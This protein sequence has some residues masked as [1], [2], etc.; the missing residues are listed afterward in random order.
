MN[1]THFLIAMAGFAVGI[2]FF[3]A[4]SWPIR[5][6]NYMVFGV[7]I[8]SKASFPDAHMARVYS[9]PGLGEQHFT[10]EVDGRSVYISPDLSP[11][12]LDEQIIWSDDGTVVSLMGE[13]RTLYIYDTKSGTGEQG[14][15]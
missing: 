4:I 8:H 2:V 1:R 6:I 9:R 11:G 7:E 5:L 3:P 15:E 10:L 14:G 12:N 13:K